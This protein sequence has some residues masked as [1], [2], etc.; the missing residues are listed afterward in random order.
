MLFVR[1]APAVPYTLIRQISN[2][3]KGERIV[4]TNH[5]PQV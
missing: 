4:G 1:V 5:A 2:V 3:E